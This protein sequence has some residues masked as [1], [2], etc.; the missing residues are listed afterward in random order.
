MTPP[1]LGETMI[2]FQELLHDK[3][4]NKEVKIKCY[5]SGKSI[6][7][8]SVPREV[9]LKCS[10]ESDKRCIGDRC[11]FHSKELDLSDEPRNLLKFIDAPESRFHSIIKGITKLSCAFK[12]EVSSVQNI[13][14]IF[15]TAPTGKERNKN[16]GN[17]VC[18]NMGLGIDVNTVYELTG[19]STTDP[20]TQSGTCIFTKATKLKS[21]I[22]SFSL[23]KIKHDLASFQVRKPDVAKIFLHLHDLYQTYARNITKIYD[24]PYLHMAIDLVFH[25]ALSFTF[26][27]E[28]VHKGWLDVMVIGDTRCGKGYVSEK[29]IEYF[30][31]GEVV[32]GD[33]ASYSGLIGGIDQ[34]AGHRVISW[35]KIPIN[36]QGLVVIDEAGEIKPED[37]TRLSRV[38]SEGVAEV[39]KIQKQITNARTRLIFLANPPLKTIASYSYGIQALV[40]VVK[41]P[42]DIARFDYALVVSHDEVPVKVINKRRKEIA[43]MYSS[44]LEQ[45]LIMWIWSRKHEQVVFS[46]EAVEELYKASI[47]LAE[48]YSFTIPLIQGENIRVK[49]AKI[50]VCFAGR[51]YSNKDGGESL[52]VQK[53]HVECAVAFLGI[54]YRN[55]FSGY[56]QM[57][58]LQRHV[59]VGATK[60]DLENAEKYFGAFTNSRG[61][62]LDCLIR[63]N[64]ITANDLVEHINIPKE[65]SHEIISK[66]IELNLVTKRSSGTYVKSPAFNSWLKKVMMITKEGK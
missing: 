24:R 42:E 13:E 10:G 41:A 37:W 27:N 57:S 54:I 20:E 21:D 5:V 52:W 65:T 12:F 28:R 26:G 59:D 49:L 9:E 35:G 38:R 18:Y 66:L 7:P 25:S 51:L 47:S 11:K 6:S 2:K 53:T 64:A 8:Y 55:E 45:E 32:S 60:K 48:Q 44:E 43:S 1:F 30:N 4:Y 34:Y 16:V 61:K 63:N 31:A 40:D 46:P 56:Y 58:K 36:D 3:H 62:L 22:E 15:I 23:L 33:N 39:V 14:R 50:A 29:L 17:Y 19:I